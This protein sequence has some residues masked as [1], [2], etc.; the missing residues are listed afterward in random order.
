MSTG[1]PTP[2]AVRQAAVDDYRTSGDSYADVAARHG[3]S[4]GALHSWVNPTEPKKREPKTWAA[5]E[6]ALTAGRWVNVR[7]VMRWQPFQHFDRNL[8]AGEIRV[9]AEEAM[10]TD[11]EAR[12]AHAAYV[13][14]FRDPRHV[15]GER[16]YQRRKKREQRQRKAAA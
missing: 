10:F 8:T 7:G 13:G 2:D 11:D 16:V 6:L 3:V 1:K 4:R 14:G 9:E 12:A 15:M 5:D